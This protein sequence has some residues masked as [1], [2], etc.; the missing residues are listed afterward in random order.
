M[1]LIKL[2]KTIVRA[3]DKITDLFLTVILCG[4]L[5]FGVYSLWESGQVYRVAE[6]DNYTPYRPA[7]DD[8]MSFTELRAVN[9]EVLAWLTVNDTPI[10]YPV[11]QTSDNEK[12]VSVNVLG[13]FALSGS[14]FLDYRNSPDFS[15]RINILYGHYMEKKLM[16]GSL[17]DYTE[18]EY[19]DSHPYGN[20]FFD[21]DNHGLEFFALVL[22]D[23]YDREMYDT[24]LESDEQL[25]AYLANVREHAITWREIEAEPGD[26]FVVLST[27]AT[28]IT[29]G[30]YLLIGRITKELHL[31]AKEKPKQPTVIRLGTGTDR[32]TMLGLNAP[33]VWVWGAVLAA[34]LSL[35]ALIELVR[36]ARTQARKRAERE[37]ER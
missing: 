15:D 24:E 9:P 18:Q 27:C 29:N 12:Y 14:I 31:Q 19:L 17:G 8:S 21:G 3:L 6:A 34:L 28:R 30:R 4:A 26:R 33:P 11:T 23:A 10:D 37:E 2:G 7:K 13:E 16:F 1:N 5:L 35:L 25:A 36:H 32:L 22:T 20:L